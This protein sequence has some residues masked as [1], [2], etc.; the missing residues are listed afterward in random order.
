MPNCCNTWSIMVFMNSV[1]LSDRMYLGHMWTGKYWLMKVETIV[2]AD[3]SGI[4]KA[5]RQPKKVVNYCEYMFISRGGCFTFSDQVHGNFWMVC[6]ESLSSEVDRLGLWLF[7]FGIGY[8]W[9]CISSCLCS[10]PSS[11][12]SVL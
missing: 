2:S 6:L 11:N 3:L 12:T 4:R 9:Q 10:F 1:P 5:S 8:S 7:L